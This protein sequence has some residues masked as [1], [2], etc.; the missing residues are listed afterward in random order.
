MNKP[1]MIAETDAVSAKYEV[2]KMLGKRTETGAL[3]L[4]KLKLKH[5]Q[6]IKLQLQGL[7]LTQISEV[8]GHPISYLSTLFSDPLVKAE[9]TKATEQLRDEFKTLRASANQAVREALQGGNAGI[10]LRAA[11][12]FYEI[13]GDKM[14]DPNTGK[15]TAEDVIKRMLQINQ[16]INVGVTVTNTPKGTSVT[17]LSA[18]E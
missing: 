15:E 14:V 17:V 2:E 12:L 9:I 4:Q 11:K 8:T 16:Q 7:S 18:E 5:L 6:L 10:K 1:I 3:K 13:E